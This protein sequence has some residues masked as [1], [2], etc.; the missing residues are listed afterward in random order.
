MLP[1]RPRRFSESLAY[2]RSFRRGDTR[3][4]YHAGIDRAALL[5]P[6]ALQNRNALLLARNRVGDA[7]LVLGCN[8]QAGVEQ[9]STTAA[10]KAP[11]APKA[12]TFV[13]PPSSEAKDLVTVAKREADEILKQ[14]RSAGAS[15]L[16]VG[17]C[18]MHVIPMPRVS[19]R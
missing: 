19:Y 15:L 17:W 14:A 7:Q 5:P 4:G 10:P 3:P 12:V 16:E 18:A 8:T 6:V 11:P 13:S 9:Q 1:I 2:S